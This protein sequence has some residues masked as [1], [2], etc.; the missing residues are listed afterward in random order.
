LMHVRQLVE[1]TT[2]GHVTFQ[3]EDHRQVQTKYSNLC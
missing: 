1:A 3:M 2:T